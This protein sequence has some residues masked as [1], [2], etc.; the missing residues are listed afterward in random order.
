MGPCQGALCQLPLRAFVLARAGNEAVSAATTARPPARP[1]RLE[2]AAAGVHFAIEQRTGLHERH[3]ELGAR[4][5]WAGAWKR[6]ETYGDALAEYWAVRRYVGMMDVG[7]LGKFLV[8]GPGATDFLERVY[9][10]PVGN[11]EAGGLRYALLLNEAGYVFDDGTIAALGGGRYYLTFTSGGAE[12]VEAWLRDW[13]DAWGSAVHIVN[14]TAAVGAINVVG[15]RSREL[16]RRLSPGPLDN[17]SFPYMHH[18]ELEVAELGCRALRL[19]FA[20]ELGYELHHARSDGVQLWN[21]LLEAGQDLGIRPHGLEALRLLRLEKAH[22]IV[23]QDTDFDSTPAKL[24]LGWAVAKGKG[25][26]VG[27][28]ALD[29]IDRLPLALRLTRLTF[30]GEPPPEGTPLAAGGGHAGHLTSSRFSPVLGEGVALGW[31]RGREGVFPEEF[32]AGGSRGRTVSEPFYDPRG[33][34]LRA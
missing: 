1:I 28:S 17:A 6:P 3:L 21:A 11:L 23:G 14:R 26:F 24:G 31:V 9:P 32:E 4:M 13:A 15:P 33:E 27:K 12:G 18:R 22:I 5:E 25:D 29:R 34:R 19:G 30:P 10:C 16:L 2:D 8:A 20:G 7:T